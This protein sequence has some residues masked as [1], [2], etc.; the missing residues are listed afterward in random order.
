M[1]AGRRGLRGIGPLWAIGIPANLTPTVARRRLAR[2][3]GLVDATGNLQHAPKLSGAGLAI[4][5]A[6]AALG[7]FVLIAPVVVIILLALGLIL[8]VI[9]WPG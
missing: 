9:D 5:G 1:V 8:G 4:V 2:D 6:G 3:R 7:T